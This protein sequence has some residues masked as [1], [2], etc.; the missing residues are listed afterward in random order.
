[1]KIEMDD[2][3]RAACI[4]ASICAAVLLLALILST[5]YTERSKAAFAAGYEEGTVP[6]FSQSVWVKSRK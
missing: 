6:G 3:T 5:D 4:V 2:N 1:M